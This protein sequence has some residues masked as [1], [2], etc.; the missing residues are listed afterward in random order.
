MNKTAHTGLQYVLKQFFRR[1]RGR[2]ITVEKVQAATPVY[3]RVQV[4]NGLSYYVRH[5]NLKKRGHAA[6]AEFL[7]PGASTTTRVLDATLYTLR[8]CPSCGYNLSKIEG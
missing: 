6:T 3:T 5:H 7:L 1:N 2:W 4:S 8:F